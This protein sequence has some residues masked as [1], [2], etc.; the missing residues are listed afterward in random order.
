MFYVYYSIVVFE[1]KRVTILL[2]PPILCYGKKI[3]IFH[4]CIKKGNLSASDIKY[5]E[6]V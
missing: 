4:K 5:K 6:T 2:K 3:F 1:K